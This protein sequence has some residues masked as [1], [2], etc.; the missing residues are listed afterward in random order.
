MPSLKLDATPVY[1][2]KPPPRNRC[3][4]CGRS[5]KRFRR[6]LRPTGF[7]GREFRYP[8]CRA[9]WQQTRSNG[10][11]FDPVCYK[12]LVYVVCGIDPRGFRPGVGPVE[13]E[14]EL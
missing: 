5:G 6:E 13:G 1:E 9:C 10:A 11:A 4:V 7:G 2:R 8:Y 12:H 3:A 14:E